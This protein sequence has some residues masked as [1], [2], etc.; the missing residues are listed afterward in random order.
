VPGVTIRIDRPDPATGVGQIMAR[1]DNVMQ[2]Y[3]Q[4]PVLTAATIDQEGWLATGDLGL[5]DEVGNLHVKG[6]LKSVI[7]LSHG[8]NIFPEAI[9]ERINALPQVLESLVVEREGRLTALVYLD[10]ELVERE[11][12]GQRPP[13][14]QLLTEIKTV[15]NQGL[16]PYSRLHQVKERTEPFIK[17]A[18]HKIK[19]YLYQ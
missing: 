3:Y 1:G 9:E 12:A 17:T 15:I 7:V 13:I 5:V 2:G 18:T 16:P 10:Y 6:R 19:R 11:A 4:N 14:Q 8:E